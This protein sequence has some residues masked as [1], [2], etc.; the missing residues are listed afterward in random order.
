[1]QPIMDSDTVLIEAYRE[2]GDQK[3]FTELVHRYREPIFQLAVSIVGSGFAAEA[4]EITQEVFV[5]VYHAL[6]TFRGESQ[7]SSWIY[8]IAFNSAVN[9]KKHMRYQVPHLNQEVLVSRASSEVDPLSRLESAQRDRELMA[10]VE[11]LPEVYQSALRLHYWMGAS[12]NEIADLLGIPENTVKSYL[13]RARR[14]LR[15][16]LERGANT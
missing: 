6:S 5:R 8:R 11:E 4:E 10:A 3:A 14:L 9:L 16:M 2:R 15:S 13:H 7:F 12:I 1:M